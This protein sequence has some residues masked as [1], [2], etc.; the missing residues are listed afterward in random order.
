[1]APPFIVVIPA[2]LAASRLPH[3]AL[4][5]IGGLPMVVRVAMQA[6]ASG[7]AR[8]LIA[9]DAQC[10]CDAAHAHGYEALL[11]RSD[12]QSGTDRIAEAARYFGWSDDT[13]IVNVQGD[14]PLIEPALIGEVAA[15]L[16]SRSDSAMATAVHPVTETAEILNP[17]IV[18]AV[19]DARG[20]ALYFSRAPIPWNLQAWPAC[21]NGQYASFPVPHTVYRHIGLYA[22]R[23]SFLRRFVQLPPAP[24]ETIEA[25]EQL[26][27]L[28]YGERIAVLVTHQ[29]PAPGVDT[30]ADLAR[31]RALFAERD[32]MA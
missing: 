23:A 29:A 22:C 21:W 11:T 6:R 19:L 9:A 18:K 13:L 28:W 16:A 14:E 2:R 20:H 4:A 8:V 5:D 26:R 12:H 27:A 15:H 31:V 24:I 32:G 30:C 3:K 1:M 7:A 17:N 10:I 25:L